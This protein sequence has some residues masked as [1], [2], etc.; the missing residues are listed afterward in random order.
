MLTKRLAPLAL[1]THTYQLIALMLHNGGFR[2]LIR[3]ITIALFVCF[4][5]S[6]GEGRKY[7][8][9]T[10]KVTDISC[11]DIWRS[12]NV[13]NIRVVSKE[14]ESPINFTSKLWNVD[15][16]Q[17]SKLISKEQEIEFQYEKAGRKGPVLVYLK[18]EGVVVVDNK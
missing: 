15:C 16:S 18:V 5:I 14:F 6:C 2:K 8:L 4:I 3:L 13:L 7:Y 10:G 17:V 12:S 1:Q 11:E 9:A